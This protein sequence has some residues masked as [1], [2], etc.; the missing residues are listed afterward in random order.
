MACVAAVWIPVP[1]LVCPIPDARRFSAAARKLPAGAL[2]RGLAGT[3]DTMAS[4]IQQIEGYYPG[5]VA[6]ANNNP[7]NLIF[8]GQPGAT[9]GAGGFA[10]WG[11]YAE[12]Y[13]ALLDQL[14]R[15]AG[16]GLTISQEMAKWAPAGQGANDPVSYAAQIAAAEGVAVDT[17]LTLAFASPAG[18]APPADFMTPADVGSALPD[19]S[20][21]VA[22]VGQ[23]DPVWLAAGAVGLALLAYA[24]VA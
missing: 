5:T 4:T 12:G 19:L 17:P 3:I 10:K 20:S 9:A 1:A 22:E 7:G 24:A 18:Q 13:Q 21:F 8:V 2:Q 6:Y 14:N 11:S 23:V 16:R 15:D